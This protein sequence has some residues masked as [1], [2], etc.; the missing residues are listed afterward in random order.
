MLSDG[1]VWEYQ[2]MPPYL[3][4]FFTDATNPED[5]SMPPFMSYS[6]YPVP[7]VHLGAVQLSPY[8]QMPYVSASSS[9]TPAPIVP[10]AAPETVT[11]ASI[12]SASLV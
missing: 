1:A 9:R 12:D 2:P 10:L 6:G 11:D 5:E 8:D 7:G 4:D 3:E